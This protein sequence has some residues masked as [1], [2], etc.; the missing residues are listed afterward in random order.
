MDGSHSASQ[1]C[2]S[3]NAAWAALRNSPLMAKR[4]PHPIPSPPSANVQVLAKDSSLS[5]LASS[6]PSGAC[7]PLTPSRKEIPMVTP[8]GK[9]CSSTARM[10]SNSLQVRWRSQAT[11]AYNDPSPRGFQLRR[12]EL[13]QQDAQRSPRILGTSNT[14]LRR[15]WCLHPSP[16]TGFAAEPNVNRW[17]R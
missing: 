10:C 6:H 7:R 5:H 9:K 4:L 16:E 3:C 17:P 12:D 15:L 11:R 14:K 2:S 13:H 8:R 1:R